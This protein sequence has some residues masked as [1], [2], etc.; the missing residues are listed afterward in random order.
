MKNIKFLEKMRSDEKS[1][2]LKRKNKINEEKEKWI[3]KRGFQVY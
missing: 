2:I 1:E 3:S